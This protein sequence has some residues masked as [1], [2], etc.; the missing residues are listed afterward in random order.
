MNTCPNCG[1]TLD[2][3]A[4]KRILFET[5]Y[6]KQHANTEMGD[7]AENLRGHMVRAR[8]AYGY[9]GAFFS[10]DTDAAWRLFCLA[11]DEAKRHLTKIEETNKGG[12]G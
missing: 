11:W 2:E 5:E 8:K 7:T 10:H 3:E 6:S 12:E 4:T 1:C 9:S